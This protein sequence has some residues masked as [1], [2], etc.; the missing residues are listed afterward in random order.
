MSEEEIFDAIV[1]GGGLS[2]LAAAYT[3][4]QEG[5]QVLVLERGDYSGAK[6]VT[7]GRI[8]INPIRDFFPDLWKKAPF[9]RH[10]THEEICMM[11]AERSLNVGYYGSELEES[12][13]SY[14]VLRGKF[15]KWFAKQAE[16][17]G[18]MIVTK[19]NVTEVVVENGRV[20]GVRTNGEELRANV[21]LACDGALSFVSQQLGMKVPFRQEDYAVGVKEVI[22][23]D[24]KVLEDRF[25]LTGDEGTARL[26]LGDATAGLFGGGFLYTN[27]DS[28]S[29]G[30]VMG[31]KDLG[32]NDQQIDAPEMLERF[33]RHPEIARL[34]EGGQS[35]EY[36]AHV[37]S[38]AGM[39][40]VGKLYGDGVLVCGDA[41][42][43][44]MNIG[45]LVRGM[46]YAMGSGYF[47]AQAVL[48]AKEKGDYSA[49]TLGVY[50][51]LL[52]DS[53]V[54][55]D[56]ESFKEA[57]KALDSPYLFERL[58]GVVGNLMRDLFEVPA[59][60]KEKMF[61]SIKANLPLGELAGMMKGV[62]GFRKL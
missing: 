3:M 27:K 60:P 12:H 34:I 40:A 18:A 7:G 49:S 62:G 57:P 25:N 5:L 4:A 48:A 53:F 16:R 21:V 8:Y 20:V 14:T 11:T 13:Q 51:K 6:N 29:V 43:F 26:Y 30:L 31:I 52:R 15:D 2:G 50:E 32:S 44:G 35:V 9:E 23:I 54:L 58:P 17:K 37:I 39:R 45:L 59:G 61:N 1:V 46:E 33:K 10:V 38:E 24:R 19:S 56:F 22:E 47:A 36:S 55:K 28:I 41:A 42:G